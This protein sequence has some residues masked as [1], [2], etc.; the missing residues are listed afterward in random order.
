MYMQMT[1][2]YADLGSMESA[3][4]KYFACDR[5][6]REPAYRYWGLCNW[7]PRILVVQPGIL[8]E[9]RYAAHRYIPCV[10]GL[11]RSA[12]RSVILG[13]YQVQ[14]AHGMRMSCLPHKRRSSILV[15]CRAWITLGASII[16]SWT[17]THSNTT[18]NEGPDS[19]I[20][21]R[22]DEAE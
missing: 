14:F 16:T 1:E 20:R 17:R 10:F 15:T 7:K 12:R 19:A 6:E 21:L 22:L 8:L 3:A 18:V 9:I 5:I 11:M 2:S 13:P 4:R